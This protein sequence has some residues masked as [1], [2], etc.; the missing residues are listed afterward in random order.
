[1]E[2]HRSNPAASPVDDPLSTEVATL[3]R[4]SARGGIAVT[5]SAAV[6][7]LVGF[8]T[9]I[10]L[11]RIIQPAE[12]G[13]YAMAATLLGFIATI[14]DFGLSASIVE[15][16][17]LDEAAANAVF[18][19]NAKLT[20]MLCLGLAALAPLATRFFHQSRIAPILLLLS[21]GLLINGVTLPL[22]GMLRRQMSFGRIALIE[23]AA[24]VVGSCVALLFAWRIA[25]AWVLTIQQLTIYLVQAIGIWIFCR[26]RPRFAARDAS[27]AGTRTFGRQLT[28]S[29][30]VAYVGDTFD[31]FIIGRM[32]SAASLG[33]YQKAEQ[34]AALPFQQL[35]VPL[36]NVVVASFTR[37]RA[38]PD[39]LA[40]FLRRTLLA[41]FAVIFP[42]AAFALIDARELILL[43]MGNN[44]LDATA[45]FRA[46]VAAG[47]L[48]VPTQ[49]SRWIYLAEGRTRQQLRWTLLAT[50]VQ[51]IGVLIG[52]HWGTAGIAAGYAIAMG[53]LAAPAM[54]VCLRGSTLIMADMLQPA[55]WPLVASIIAAAATLALHVIVSNIA[56]EAIVFAVIYAGCWLATKPARQ[57]AMKLIA[58][59]LRRRSVRGE[60][61]R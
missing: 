13:V 9:L 40:R 55:C 48:S 60:E 2:F 10:A 54:L 15:A 14:R 25:G 37:A 24:V 22:A 17:Q 27:S 46:L 39:V 28:G 52:L 4:Q 21:A 1:M 41:I 18:W 31:Q 57:D 56:A 32:F 36:T 58:M 49:V 35:F 20:V 3:A 12:F 7:T 16:D 42:I 45:L 23:A 11:T 29:R 38:Q 50:P 43:L 19:L 6:Q 34:W 61:S 44:W 8:A 30:I 26:W 5:V 47:V 51:I 33:L 59:L 53:L